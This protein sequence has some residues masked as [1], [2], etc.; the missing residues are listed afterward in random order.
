MLCPHCGHND[1]KVIDS[2]DTGDG[3]RRRREC[4]GCRQRFTTYE[5]VQTTSLLVVKRD[6]R[7]E[8]FQRQKLFNSVRLACAKRPLPTGA[9]DR[10]VNDI[11]AQLLRIGKQEVASST[12][13]ELVMERLKGLDRVGYIRY[14][15]VYR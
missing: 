13:G 15:S 7:R 14:A 12:I 5:R 3:V 10:L 11:E 1:S 9:L 4:L 8:E 2:R 6:G